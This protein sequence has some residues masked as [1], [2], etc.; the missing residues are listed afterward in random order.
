[1]RAGELPVID[2]ASATDLAF[3]AMDTGRVPQ[4]IAAVLILG[5]GPDVDV[6]RARELMAQRIPEV[7]R[8]RQRLLRVP[9]GCG[10][11]IWVDDAD[12]DLRRHLREVRCPYP[13]DER[14]LLDVAATMVTERLPRSRPL[15]SVAFITGPVGNV[16]ALVI[17]IHHVL[18]DGIGGLAV[19]ASLVDHEARQPAAAFP[20]SPPSAGRL[21]VDAV[22]S[23]LRTLSRIR[24]GWRR[25]RV[26]MAAGGGLMPVRAA[27]CSLVRRTGPARRLAVVRADLAP[28]RAAAHRQGGTV[29]D[30]VLTAVAGALRRVLAGRGES[31]DR[32]AIAVPVA[33]RRSAAASELGNQVSP[34]LVTVAGTGDPTTIRRVAAA[35]RARKELA[36]GPPPIAVLG[37]LFRVVAATGAFRWY[38]NHQRRLHTLVSTVRGPEQPIR[39]AGTAIAAIIPV[40]VAEAGNTTVSFEVLSYAGTVTI[41]AIVDP[42]HFPDLATLTDGLEA[43]LA[44]LSSQTTHNSLSH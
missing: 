13:A 20:R 34:M 8:L 38:M 5:A 18:A 7:P 2:R 4:Q 36:A 17:V 10:R 23:R 22:K 43:E 11:A 15:W 16:A 1:M 26:S 28:L 37:T 25:L 30:A 27:P 41:T 35:V 24:T 14:A 21:A 29:N 33:G 19:L 44:L 6:S 40:A 32:L 42:D 12:F 31:V 9:L 3:L 39:F